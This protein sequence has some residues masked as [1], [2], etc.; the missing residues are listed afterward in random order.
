MLEMGMPKERV[1]LCVFAVFG[2]LLGDSVFIMAGDGGRVHVYQLQ[3]DVDLS[4]F[5]NISYKTHSLLETR[6][7][8][9][10][11]PDA[12]TRD[13][14]FIKAGIEAKIKSWDTLE[15]DTLY[16]RAQT[17]SALD[18]KKQYPKLSFRSLKQL[19]TLAKKDAQ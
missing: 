2:L 3:E 10:F 15:R 14:A 19:Q 16:L 17:M 1:F 7:K 5:N 4:D 8:T 6:S 11:L 9:E 13:R 12:T 18:L